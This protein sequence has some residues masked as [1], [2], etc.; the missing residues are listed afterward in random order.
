MHGWVC[1]FTFVSDPKNIEIVSL[2]DFKHKR[3]FCLQTQTLSLSIP[4]HGLAHVPEHY[5][6]TYV[7]THVQVYS[8]CCKYMYIYMCMYVCVL[9]YMH[10]SRLERSVVRPGQYRCKAVVWQVSLLQYSMWS[11]THYL[12]G[13]SIHA[14]VLS[15]DMCVECGVAGNC[16]VR[17]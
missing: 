8:M 1:V 4:L 15:G 6:Y 14:C 12:I 9:W 7:Y 11:K 3:T 5:I 16:A 13:G 10:T 2:C 17:G